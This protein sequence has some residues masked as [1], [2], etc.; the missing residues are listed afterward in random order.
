MAAYQST[1]TWADSAT[2]GPMTEGAAGIA[3]IVLSILGLAAIS[4]GIL[5]SVA[6][7]VVG[8]GLLIEA[9]N[10]GMEY[11]RAASRA[12]AGVAETAE[13]GADVT[14]ELMAGVAGI[15]LGVLSL[16]AAGTIMHLLP[17]ALIVFGGALL[18]AGF[19]A[20]SISTVRGLESAS[21]TPV[22]TMQS[23]L[24][25]A[26]GVQVLVGVTAI[27]LGILSFVVA[28]AGTLLIVGLLVVGAAL[29]ATSANFTQSFIKLL[30]R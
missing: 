2:V 3:V 10:T 5:T 29:L 16:L 20:T 17:A 6:T 11:S 26:R 19:S 14:V 15:V 1:S 25:P 21:G 30:A 9:G 18:L 27:V 22:I 12:A 13:L 24:A 28:A 23:E 7:I 8:V 4:P